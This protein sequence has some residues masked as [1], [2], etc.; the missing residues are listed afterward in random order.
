MRDTG[1]SETDGWLYWIA[2]GKKDETSDLKST[3]SFRQNNG[4]WQKYSKSYPSWLI[5]KG[6][7]RKEKNNLI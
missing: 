4:Q 7:K 3:L 1:N 5:K 6:K 2:P